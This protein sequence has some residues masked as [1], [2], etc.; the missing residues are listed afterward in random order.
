MFDTQELVN[1]I[2]VFIMVSFYFLVN[3]LK[4]Y[5]DFVHLQYIM[6]LSRDPDYIRIHKTSVGTPTKIEPKRQQRICRKDF[7]QYYLDLCIL[8][9]FF[10]A[11]YYP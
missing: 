7:L 11:T 2:D 1:V 5:G 8:I 9:S 6:K 10:Y 3:Q 4:I